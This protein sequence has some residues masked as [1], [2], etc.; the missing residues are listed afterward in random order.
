MRHTAHRTPHS[1]RSPSHHTP[2]TGHTRPTCINSRRA[3]PAPP[4]FTLP[5][6]L[7]A[8]PLSIDHTPFRLDEYQRVRAAGARV[9]SADQLAGDREFHDDWE[10][11][12]GTLNE[13]HANDDPPRLWK[14]DKNIPGC[15]FTRSIGDRVA[16]T[17]GVI[18]WP[19]TLE[20][21]IDTSHEYVIVCSDGVFEFLSNQAVVDIVSK[22]DTSLAG[23]NALVQ[24]AYKLWL[25]FDLRSDDITAIVVRLEHEL[26]KP[27]YAAEAMPA[28]MRRRKSS[29]VGGRAGTSRV[30][31]RRSAAFGVSAGVDFVSIEQLRPTRRP[32]LSRKTKAVMEGN[33]NTASMPA[34]PVRV[35]VF[36][37]LSPPELV[38]AREAVEGNYL[39]AGLDEDQLDEVVPEFRSVRA[40][41]GTNIIEQGNRGDW[42]YVL[43]DGIIDVFV[44]D[45]IG[46]SRHVFTYDAS[47]PGPAPSFGELALISGVPRAAT[48]R[49]RT[50]AKLWRLRSK[51]FRERLEK[52]SPRAELVRTLRSV[53]ILQS[54]SLSETQLLAEALE[55]VQRKEG[56]VV[57]EQGEISDTF[58]I[59]HKGTVGLSRKSDQGEAPAKLQDL[60]DGQFF[61][62]RALLTDAPRNATVTVLTPCAELYYIGRESFETIL[63]SLENIINN[64]RRRRE[65]NYY[66]EQLQAE[67]RQLL[68][69]TV[70]S[71]LLASDS[72]DCAI[73]D[74]LST[75]V[76]A[77]SK[78]TKQVYS[79]RVW[80][81]TRIVEELAQRR[82][83]HSVRMLASLQGAPSLFVPQ[84]I[85]VFEDSNRLFT[86][87]SSCLVC[88]LNSLRLQSEGGKFDE[89]DAK[90]L[91]ACCV[92]ALESLHLQDFALRALCSDTIGMT[93]EGFA[94]PMEFSYA[95]RLS[96]NEDERSSTVC[97]VP[98]YRAPEMV[99]GD[100]HTADVDLWALGVLLYEMI[101]GR[102][103]FEGDTELE[104]HNRIRQHVGTTAGDAPAALGKDEKLLSF[105][106]EVSDD[107]RDVIDVLLSPDP[108]VRRAGAG[109][110]LD[111]L[112]MLP[113]LCEIDW[114]S[115]RN[116]E[117]K[118]AHAES[119]Q[120]RTEKKY[121]ELTS[122]D[123]APPEVLDVPVWPRSR[124]DRAPRSR[125]E[126]A[127]TTRPPPQQ[128]DPTADMLW[129][130]GFAAKCQPRFRFD[131]SAGK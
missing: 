115:M 123:S 131:E 75:V 96:S 2:L 20:L 40:A 102:M 98:S 78:I 3:E 45:G 92:L 113:W 14:R 39:F 122:A 19:E 68:T 59:I 111:T 63:G 55:H 79:V 130:D 73:K 85:C 121:K 44:R 41:S 13:E 97:G 5:G 57:V 53:R 109:Q 10:M 15:A 34:E 114:D 129:C 11:D 33:K 89:A 21:E 7:I 101:V 32:V 26:A 22:C 42:F 50:D 64:D 118:G 23:C 1:P 105:P 69:S 51:T 116:G 24:E 16:R 119:L 48:V 67:T 17:I 27:G 56:E 100:G 93:A 99:G 47:L 52:L 83:M 46:D 6:K 120:V 86:V 35:E 110:G 61:G 77:E 124:R 12:M 112:R 74:K 81:R 54:L 43:D 72:G 117:Q 126:I 66:L 90:Y 31:R 128:V 108:T 60:S 28:R 103:P 29:V 125:A 18:P 87:Y 38:R 71:Y 25:Q 30:T 106:D 8:Y 58:Y 82:M 104:V 80:S 95:K 9:M 91:C 65:K 62:E 70:S 76:I 84:L 127:R 49:A 88:T 36:G 37:L 107:A 94:Q 4:R